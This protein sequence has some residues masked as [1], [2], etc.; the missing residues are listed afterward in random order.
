MGGR[1]TG[2]DSVRGT[3]KKSVC[4]NGDTALV[5]VVQG[6]VYIHQLITHVWES[7]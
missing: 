4:T 2:K 1:V 5:V 7:A 6:S 3:G